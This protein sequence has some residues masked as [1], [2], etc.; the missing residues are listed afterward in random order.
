M[1]EKIRALIAEKILEQGRINI[2]IKNLSVMDLLDNDTLDRYLQDKEN[3]EK[4]IV[5]LREILK[6]L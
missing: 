2:V 1:K 3:L 6:S 4:D 5:K